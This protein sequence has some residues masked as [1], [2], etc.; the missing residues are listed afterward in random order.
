M[1]LHYRPGILD[2]RTHERDA[3][4]PVLLAFA[5]ARGASFYEVVGD[6]VAHVIGPSFDDD[7]EDPVPARVEW[8]IDRE[9]IAAIRAAWS[10]VGGDMPAACTDGLPLVGVPGI[11]LTDL[12]QQAAARLEDAW[13][14]AAGVMLLAALS[15]FVDDIR[16]CMRSKFVFA[17]SLGVAP[18]LSSRCCC[19]SSCRSASGSTG[20]RPST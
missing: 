1:P 9:A 7:S 19:R 14:N 20:H 17:H 4:E 15:R 8:L 3:V 16:M 6:G 5:T 10:K 13:D 18:A 11:D 12:Y 2:G